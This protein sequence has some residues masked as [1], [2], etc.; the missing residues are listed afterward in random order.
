MMDDIQSLSWKIFQLLPWSLGSFAWKKP[1]VISRRYSSHS[2]E[3]PHGEELRPFINREH[4]LDRHKREPAWKQILQLQSNLKKAAALANIHLNLMRTQS[5]NH[6]AKSLLNTWS[7]QHKPCS[8]HPWEKRFSIL[9]ICCFARSAFLFLVKECLFSSGKP[10]VWV[11]QCLLPTP[12]PAQKISQ[13]W[14]MRSSPG[15]CWKYHMANYQS[16]HRR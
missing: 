3:R 8:L 5:Q 10:S 15:L 12:T 11:G 2:M 4:K 6:S 16:V 14:S 1:A 7:P 13:T 9:H